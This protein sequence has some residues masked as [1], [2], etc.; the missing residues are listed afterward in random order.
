MDSKT[1][2]KLTNIGK[3]DY[4][5][6]VM[7]KLTRNI[8]LDKGESTYI[9]TCAI[10]FIEE[11]NKNR[12]LHSYVELAYYIIL[13]YALINNDYQPLY[14]FATNFGFYP[15]SN[16]IIKNKLLENPSLEDIITNRK[17]LKYQNNNIV[18]TLEQHII[19]KKY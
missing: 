18:E 7:E 9:L 13:K 16:A 8:L 11:F 12:T 6:K 2:H 17:V 5:N 3:I 15:I 10:L 4:F 1:K 14:D 19:R